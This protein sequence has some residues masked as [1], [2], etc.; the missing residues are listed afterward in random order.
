MPTKTEPQPLALTPIRAS[1]VLSMNPAD[2]V[3]YRDLSAHPGL[4]YSIL[5]LMPANDI[6]A[7]F[8]LT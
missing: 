5:S 8:F 2:I 7:H 3:A 6:I 1:D 4:N